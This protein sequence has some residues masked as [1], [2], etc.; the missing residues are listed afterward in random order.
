MNAN[1]GDECFN[2]KS[3]YHKGS[4][5]ETHNFKSNQSARSN[6]G[7]SFPVD[8]QVNIAEKLDR[9]FSNFIDKEV[10]DKAN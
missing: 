2:R 9:I 4:M 7:S 5:P 1:Q 10:K 6:K 3:D 8:F